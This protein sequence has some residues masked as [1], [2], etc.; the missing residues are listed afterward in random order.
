MA[1]NPARWVGPSL[2]TAV[3]ALPFLTAIRDT[4]FSFATV[5]G[6]S[7]APTLKSGDVVLVRRRDFPLLLGLITGGETKDDVQKRVDR[8][9]WMQ[10]I[11][12]TQLTTVPG[13][14][15]VVRNPL[16]LNNNH[17][18]QSDRLY[19]KRV[20]GVGGQWLV[21]SNLNNAFRLEELPSY[22]VFVQ[23]DNVDNSIDS[24]LLGPISRNLVIGKAEYIVWPP[25]RWQRL[26][27]RTTEEEVAK[28]GNIRAVWS[29]DDLDE[30]DDDRS[31]RV[32]KF[33]LKAFSL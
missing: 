22:T 4:T 30:A 5:Q 7:M 6:E 1:T 17:A 33:C 20:I 16:V 23:G 27:T 25:T 11:M 9:D 31:Y 19:I 15:V 3:A 32:A 2:A 26:Y 18:A 24:R 8:N 13:E 28:G 29:R 10:G 21:H 14:I 12:A